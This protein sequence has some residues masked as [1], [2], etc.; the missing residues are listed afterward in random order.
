MRMA[1]S[2]SSFRH[3][4]MA[5]VAVGLWDTRVNAF[6]KDEKRIPEKAKGQ[7]RRK[8]CGGEL[9]VLWYLCRS[10]EGGRGWHLRDQLLQSLPMAEQEV[11]RLTHLTLLVAIIL[12][13]PSFWSGAVSL[14]SVWL[15]QA[16]DAQGKAEGLCSCR[17]G[18]V[19][20]RGESMFLSGCSQLRQCR[21]DGWSQDSCSCVRRWTELSKE[22][23]SSNK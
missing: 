1:C 12:L 6:L 13:I 23:K 5:T 22:R 18:T 9:S 14:P 11:C 8:G 15:V 19:L 4:F 3:L 10:S 16:A 21:W 2:C 7:S 17:A 20:C